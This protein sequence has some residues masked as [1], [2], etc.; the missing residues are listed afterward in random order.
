MFSDKSSQSVAHNA[1]K[2]LPRH[3]GSPILGNGKTG[4]FLVVKNQQISPKLPAQY[5]FIK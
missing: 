5:Y 2:Y 4:F 1:L 3:G